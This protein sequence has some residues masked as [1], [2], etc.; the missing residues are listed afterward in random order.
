MNR[1]TVTLA[2]LGGRGVAG[3]VVFAMVL[4]ACT[5]TQSPASPTTVPTTPPSTS[6]PTS[7]TT[8]LRP[9]T[10]QSTPVTTSTVSLAER[11]CYE[12]TPRGVARDEDKERRAEQ[13]E[14]NSVRVGPV[15]FGNAATLDEIDLESFGPDADG[16]Y[17]AIKIPIVVDAGEVV[18]VEIAPSSLSWASLLYTGARGRGS[19]NLADG[20][21]AVRFTACDEEAWASG[22]GATVTPFFNGGFIVTAPG[23]LELLV[24]DAD[25]T[26]PVVIPIGPVEC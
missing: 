9:A 11:V 5:S 17:S 21:Q 2:R 3:V 25:Q 16:L 7:P 19:Y 15:L 24:T 4:A 22:G 10:T 18:T 1:L 23:C 13:E 8:V 6:S 14:K 12:G 20:T 26:L